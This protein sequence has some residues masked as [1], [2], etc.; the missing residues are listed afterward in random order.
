[1]YIA[2]IFIPGPLLRG[3]PP[4][5]THVYKLLAAIFV[6]LY[7]RSFHFLVFTDIRHRTRGRDH[8]YLNSFGIAIGYVWAAGHV[9]RDGVTCSGHR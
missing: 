2:Y 9:N 7:C 4:E 3:N 1:M 8:H 6:S 5:R